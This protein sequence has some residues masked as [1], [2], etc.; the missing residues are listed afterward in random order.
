MGR[1]GAGKSSL[2]ETLYLISSCAS[3]KDIIRDEMKLD[4]LISRRGGR[5][6][7]NTSKDVLWHQIGTSK[8]IIVKLRVDGQYLEFHVLDKSISLGSHRPDFPVRLLTDEG[9]VKLADGYLMSK[10]EASYTRREDLLKQYSDVKK[11]L[12]GV[13]FIDHKLLSKPSL[14]ERYAW[15]KVVSKRLDKEIVS[16]VRDEFKTDAEGLTF[17]PIGD[18]YILVLQT[19]KTTVRIDDLGDGARIAILV[20]LLLLASNP[21]LVLIEEPENHMHPV[22]LRS[23]T[24]FIF[25]L[26]KDKNFQLLVSTHSVEFVSIAKELAE[27]L[28]IESSVIYLERDSDGT[29]TS[30]NFSLDD[31]ELLRKLGIDIRLLY[32]F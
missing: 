1:N 20:S 26:A 24:D 2:L 4:Y 19:S 31:A 30:Q 9:L 32:V 25:K 27:N 13:L 22:G 5:G 29:V 3:H 21:T 15:A 28:G 6:S 7:W 10:T 23:L 18:T 14:I 16:M 12:E 8:N 17:V 11:L